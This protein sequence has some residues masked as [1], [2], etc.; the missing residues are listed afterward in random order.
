MKESMYEALQQLAK[1]TAKRVESDT[2]EQQ[3]VASKGRRKRKGRGRTVATEASSI[4]HAAKNAVKKG[5]DATA[6]ELGCLRAVLAGHMPRGEEGEGSKKEESKRKAS[7]RRA[8]RAIRAAQEASARMQEG[9]YREAK[10]EIAQRNAEEGIRK[11]M[12][13]VVGAW[14]RAGQT[15]RLN[16]A[17]R[18][19]ERED[20]EEEAA[21]VEGEEQEAARGE[22]GKETPKK[23]EQRGA[24]MQYE[25]RSTR[26]GRRGR[27][28]EDT[29]GWSMARAL[30]EYKRWEWR[31]KGYSNTKE[32]RWRQ[33]A[34]E[35]WEKEAEREEGANREDT[36]RGAQDMS[37]DEN[38]ASTREET[39][40]DEEQNQ[41][42][43][44]RGARQEREDGE[45]RSSRQRGDHEQ[46]RR[47]EQDG[48]LHGGHE[49]ADEQR[50]RHEELRSE[51]QSGQGQSGSE[52]TQAAG[53]GTERTQQ[54]EERVREDSSTSSRKRKGKAKMNTHQMEQLDAQQSKATKPPSSDEEDEED[55]RQRRRPRGREDDL[56]SSQTSTR[57]H[58][59]QYTKATDR[60]H[61]T[62]SKPTK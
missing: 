60:R 25:T 43:R 11:W 36:D 35:R 39:G 13:P 62:T 2:E 27:A 49:P 40:R 17:G 37:V 55:E 61:P 30:A 9:W 54:R 12:G 21:R 50:N 58:H 23:G 22:T 47:G 26:K 16:P 8:V 45:E 18:R 3:D 29:R 32:E 31:G 41:R 53:E 52:P 51:E 57:K 42:K 46:R 6:Q 14:K 4:A 33:M 44:G 1:V 34:R 5:K 19:V 20:E 28:Q 48:G 10:G 56:T 24:G 59:G 38:T 7:T 15:W